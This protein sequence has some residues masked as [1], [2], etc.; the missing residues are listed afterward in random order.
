MDVVGVGEVDLAQ[1]VDQIPQQVTAEQPVVHMR[2]DRRERVLGISHTSRALELAKVGQ[3]L[4]IDELQQR[5]AG[6]MLSAQCDHW[7]RSTM[8]SLW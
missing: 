6:E 4:A 8:V 1:L 2:E 5:I 3:Q 7:K